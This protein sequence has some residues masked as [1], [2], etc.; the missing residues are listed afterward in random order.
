MSTLLGAKTKLPLAALLTLLV[1]CT[2]S[3]TAG[4]AAPTPTASMTPAPIASP[5]FIRNST[6]P[7][8]FAE[9][10]FVV[11]PEDLPYAFTTAP[12]RER[13]PLDGTYLRI[14]TIEAA[15]GLLP[16]RCL[17]CPPYFPNAGVSTLVLYRGYYW[18]DHQLSEFRALGMYTVAGHRITLFNDPWC[19]QD[20]GVYRWSYRNGGL[21]FEALSGACVYEEARAN[22]LSKVPWTKIKP[23]VYRIEHLWPGPLSC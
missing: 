22:D 16:F 1:A 5:T 10:K 9:K 15:D 14:L 13:S 20:R 12:P 7:I 8:E 2:G 19:P 21:A 18:L 3:Q 4:S 6:H 11:P 17:R 23:C